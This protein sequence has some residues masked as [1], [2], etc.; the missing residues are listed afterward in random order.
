MRNRTSRR[1]LGSSLR[2]RNDALI[3]L[4]AAVKAPSKW[5]ANDAG[6]AQ[7]DMQFRLVRSVVLRRDRYTCRGCE[8]WG[9]RLR[10]QVHHR[11]NDH[12]NNSPENLVTLC[13]FCHAVFHAGFH[14]SGLPNSIPSKWW[15]A[16]EPVEGSL[17]M[18]VSRWVLGV[19]PRPDLPVG[20]WMDEED[21]ARFITHLTL[22]AEGRHNDV[23]LV[24]QLR[25]CAVWW[26]TLTA[27]EVG[28]IGFRGNGMAR[29]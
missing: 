15:L 12:Q 20:D 19:G 16:N 21:L 29:G 14:S 2:K 18:R 26:P 1:R 22:Q 11:D 24:D 6:S 3:E 7:A 25:V 9:G 10:L 4:R 5:R 8:A 28:R 13:V 17:Q 27:E 23:E